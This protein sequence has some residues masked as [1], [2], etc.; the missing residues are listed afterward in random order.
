MR[1]LQN[2][3]L[4]IVFLSLLMGL[5]IA[6]SRRPS[7]ETIA[8]DVQNKVATDPDTKD[9]QISVVAKDGRVTLSGRANTPKAQQKA[10]QI[11]REE[12][13]SAGVDDQTTVEPEA[14]FCPSGAAATA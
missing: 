10:E 12:P 3:S 9:S 5:S 4:S 14:T 1:H 2:L 13:G 8:K 7:D 11:A 6:C